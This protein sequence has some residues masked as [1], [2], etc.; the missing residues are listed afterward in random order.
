MAQR[1]Q[2]WYFVSQIWHALLAQEEIGIEISCLPYLV[3]TNRWAQM[4]WP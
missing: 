4:C 3:F 1:R 2:S